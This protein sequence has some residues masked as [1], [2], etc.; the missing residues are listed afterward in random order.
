M[1]RS[2]LN[3]GI[4]IFF[5]VASAL[6]IFFRASLG[7][8]ISADLRALLPTQTNTA[9]SVADI[10]ALFERELVVSVQP[11][12]KASAVASYLKTSVLF[13]N[14]R[15]PNP[16]AL[17]PVLK[18]HQFNLLTNADRELLSA[19]DP[20]AL[21]QAA[22][23][24]LMGS[25]SLV[26]PFTVAEDPFGTLSRYLESIVTNLGVEESD[27]ATLLATLDID[28]F[29][30]DAQKR[31]TAFSDTLK[32]SFPNVAINIEG[33]VTHA[34]VASN[35]AVKEVTLI[36]GLS[37]LL[38][39]ILLI[40]SFRSLAPLVYIL[41]IIGASYLAALAVVLL[42]FPK[43]HLIT[44]VFGATLVGV[45]VD[46]GFHY[47]NQS[48]ERRNN[49]LFAAL[50]LAALTS[51]CAYAALAIP[52]FPGLRQMAVVGVVGLLTALGSVYAL[53]GW[54]QPRTC[55]MA[56]PDWHLSHASAFIAVAAFI[57]SAYIL[58]FASFNDDVRSYT[59][60]SFLKEKSARTG[61]FERGVFFLV[62]GADSQQALER[63]EAL[64][65][66]LL[67]EQAVVGFLATS[68]FVPSH[69]RQQA[70]QAAFAASNYPANVEQFLRLAGFPD[71]I[72]QQAT[73]AY[74]ARTAQF[75]QIDAV[76]NLTRGLWW[77]QD[78]GEVRST[79]RLRGINDYSA[80]IKI[81]D[82]HIGVTLIN[83]V[84]QINA[85]METYR[86]K[87][88][89]ALLIAVVM[90]LMMLVVRRGLLD[91]WQT[92][93]PAIGSLPISLCLVSLFGYDLNLFHLLAS[94]MVLG[95]GLDFAIIQSSSRSYSA[96]QAITL[97][98]L[99]TIASFGVLTLSET[100]AVASFGVIVLIG[101]SL[102]W[103]FT[104]LS[105]SRKMA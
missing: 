92:A 60:N 37:V 1:K 43:L 91:G 21:H 26:R 78:H 82:T 38:V 7:P 96:L 94:F 69:L 30:L 88:S 105:I 72:L 40:L 84:A 77:Q 41:S 49:K 85:V 51:A 32:S 22:F 25:P 9:A 47:L 6:F 42:L 27:Q 8:I 75:I 79:V 98:M 104:W 53:Q 63:E 31:F 101:T 50:F 12:T 87:V 2:R 52:T 64:I 17:L 18:H 20:A 71:P 54:V 65:E 70:N 74:A 5:L 55:R 19:N 97:A 73:N 46:Y 62:T 24:H 68:L 10:T 66:Q 83:P 28:P 57:A 36:G 102:T 33:V 103:I 59:N 11:A 23:A 34:T 80:L 45:C 4:W 89:I 14:V 15:V 16:L 56:V 99:T 39:I 86:Q 29:D 76:P 90:A 67:K 81:A 100:P 48:P 58:I 13:E 61:N 95:L 44:L 35:Q 3:L 93:L